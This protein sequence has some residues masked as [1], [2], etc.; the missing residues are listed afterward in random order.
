MKKMSADQWP[1]YWKP[2]EIKIKHGLFFKYFHQAY[3]CF[4]ILDFRLNGL[5]SQWAYLITN[6]KLYLLSVCGE[7]SDGAHGDNTH[8]PHPYSNPTHPTTPIQS[9]MLGFNPFHT[10]PISEIRVKLSIMKEVMF[11]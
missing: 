6:H 1:I 4:D 3:K 10:K 8:L 5:R 7:I 9:K 11:M 2:Q